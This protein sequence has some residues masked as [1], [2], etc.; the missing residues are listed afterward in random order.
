MRACWCGNS[1]IA[2][3]SQGYGE[4]LACG[5]LVYLPDMPPGHLLVHDDESDFYGKQYWLEHQHNAFG[6]GDIHARARHDLT[7]R[8]LHWLKVLLKYRLPPATIIELGCSHGSFVALLRQAGYDAS[9]VE[10]SP[11]VV[12]F[13][14]RTFGVSISVGPIESLSI[15]EGSLDVIVLMDVLE[16]LSDPMATMSHCLRLLKP[17]GLLLIQTPQFKEE[18]RY[19]SLLESK[20]RFLEMLIPEEHIYLFSIRS[21][22]RLFQQL[23]AE[24]VQFEPAIFDHYDMFFAVSRKPLQTHAS[25]EVESALLGTPQ[26]RLSLALLDLRARELNLMQALQES[27]ADRAARWEQIETLTKMVQESEA[28]RA[29]RG[30][31]TQT[32]TNLLKKSKKVGEQIAALTKMLQGC[33]EDRLDQGRQ[34]ETLTRMVHE[35]EADRAARGEQ[36]EMLTRMV[37]ESESSRAAQAEQIEIL[38]RMLRERGD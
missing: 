21:A 36:I 7:E 4:C 9:G 32:L 34:I 8:N 30:D 31:Q 35:S 33:E 24:Q 23:G 20:D 6:F 5:T 26:G 22:A 1:D 10:L 38:N 13:G 12:D 25:E 11:W 28:D 17:E 16:H 27:E 37:R 3:F 2:P 29:A 15:P 19:Q 14:S 18:F